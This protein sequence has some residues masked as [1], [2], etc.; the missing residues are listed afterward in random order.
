V[1]SS[2]NCTLELP[3]N[4]VISACL[5]YSCVPYVGCQPIPFDCRQNISV[6]NG[7]CEVLLCNNKTSRCELTGGKCFKLA[8]LIAGVTGGGIAG[9]VCAG[10]IALLTIGG[11][12]LALASVAEDADENAITHNP[13]YEK[14]GNSGIS[15]LHDHEGSV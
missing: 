15:P 10:V 2:R 4:I 5:N 6:K 3:S 1:Y 9:I 13:L 7:S 8:A 12:T 11:G 14:S